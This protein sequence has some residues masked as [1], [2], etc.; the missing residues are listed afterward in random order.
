MDTGELL[1]PIFK[2]GG[3]KRQLLD[4]I[5]QKIP[6]K[7]TTFYEPFVGGAAVLMG[8]QPK[9]AII[10]DSNPE[11]INTYKVIKEHPDELIE[12]LKIHEKNNS[13]DYYYK[14]R[15]LDRDDIEYGKLS[16]VEKAARSIYMN[17]TCFNGLYRV[18]K[19]G[20]FN[21]PYGRYVHPLI[22][23]EE[24]IRNFS[25]YLM[26]NNIKIMCGDY[27]ESLKNI[28]KGSF[29]YFDPPYMPLD[30]KKDSF[31]LYTVDVFNKEKQTELKEVCD[32]LDRKKI[33]F[34]L[35]NSNCKFI[36]ELYHDYKIEIVKA[37]HYVSA[38]GTK[39]KVIDEV[40]VTNY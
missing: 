32:Y 12:L 18:N 39:R 6:D 35:S 2:W 34:M 10:N 9:K 7:I 27:K 19:L 22:V 17:R 20:Q 14:I 5:L 15:S 21:T 1:T 33:K 16:D 30:D 24:R 3:G 25:H 23:C 26:D 28:R 29:V 37:R 8:L 40:L 31:I 36:N 4:E 13:S 11:L 38:E